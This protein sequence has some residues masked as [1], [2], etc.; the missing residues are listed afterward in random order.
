MVAF[1]SCG[2]AISRR[3]LPCHA[4]CRPP[5]HRGP[6]RRLR[7]DWTR[8]SACAR[9]L[10]VT[11][12]DAF[13][14]FTAQIAGGAFYAVFI[15]RRFLHWGMKPRISNRVPIGAKVDRAS[16]RTIH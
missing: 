6:E 10:P 4:R 14:S 15:H 3:S 2:G 7:L 13:L 16:A 12:A 5:G 1:Q 11:L 8:P 9:A